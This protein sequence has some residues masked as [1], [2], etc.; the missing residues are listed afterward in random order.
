MQASGSQ[1]KHIPIPSTPNGSILSSS[2]E[3]VA[4]TLNFI[5][6]V[7]PACP[8]IV[9]LYFAD[10]STTS[11]LVS[12]ITNDLK[13]GSDYNI[14]AAGDGGDMVE[15]T[16]EAP[17]GLLELRIEPLSQLP[18]IISGIQLLKTPTCSHQGLVSLDTTGMH[19]SCSWLA[20]A[21]TAMRTLVSGSNAAHRCCSATL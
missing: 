13:Q 16:V 17:V 8:L 10:S 2:C 14:G 21:A 11:R 3:A 12:I 1:I 20:L 5:F 9:R 7:P 6:T 19:C 15:L 4:S 18:A